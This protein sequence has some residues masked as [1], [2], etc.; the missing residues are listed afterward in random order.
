MSSSPEIVIV[1]VEHTAAPTLVPGAR[2]TLVI[3]SGT[4]KST[5]SAVKTLHAAGDQVVIFRSVDTPEADYST[6][7]TI[8]ISSD[9]VFKIPAMMSAQ[10]ACSYAAAL[11]AA[12]A[13]LKQ[14]LQISFSA[15]QMRP[16]QRTGKLSGRRVAIIGGETDLAAALTQVLARASHDTDIFLM[17]CIAD[18]EALFQRTSHLVRLGSCYAIDGETPD[19]LDYMGLREKGMEV[20]INTAVG[21]PVRLDLLSALERR[22]TVIEC[23][24][25]DIMATLEALPLSDVSFTKTLHSMLE[26]AADE[27]AK[28]VE[29]P[30]GCVI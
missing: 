2:T 11:V 9:H 3:A 8:E 22:Q 17:T 23:S 15:D 13:I 18:Q 20:I 1:S 26:E 12:I 30:V 5:R 19:L 14:E 10:T 6:P 7:G 4:V 24:E 28:Y 21:K 16:R 29:P 27:F 25:I